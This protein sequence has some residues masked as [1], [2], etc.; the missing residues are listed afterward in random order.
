MTQRN[1]RLAARTFGSV[2]GTGWPEIAL[3]LVICAVVL[4]SLVVLPLP[5]NRSAPPGALW[6]LIVI[7]MATVAITRSL[8]PRFGLDARAARA[9]PDPLYT[10]DLA[11][12]IL[13]GPRP[14]VLLAFVAA[15][16]VAL[17]RGRASRTEWIA[18][19]RQTAAA[20][21]AT[22]VAALVYRW[23]SRLLAPPMSLVH[24]HLAAALVAAAVLLV[25]V[26]V[27]RALDDGPRAAPRALAWRAALADQTMRFQ[28]LML[29]IGPLLPLAEVLDDVEAELAWLL[30]LVPLFAIYYLALVSIRMEQRTAELQ[31]TVEQLGVARQREVELTGYA[32]LVT[33]AQEE[34]RRRL[35]RDLH[36]DTAQTLV[37]LSRGLDSLSTQTIHSSP[38]ARDVRFVED[39][40]EL[41]KRSLESIRRACQD[42]R[43]SVLDDLGLSAALEIASQRDD[44]ARADLRVSPA[45]RARAVAPGGRGDDL[46]HRPGG[47]HQRAPS[48]RGVRGRD[49]AGVSAVGAAPHRAGRW[50]R[51]RLPR[52]VRRR[53]P[54]GGSGAA[55]SGLGLLGMRERAA[56][57]GAHLEITSAAASGT[58][59]SVDV[60]AL[61]ET[62]AEIPATT[63]VESH[64]QPP[65]AVHQE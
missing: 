9:L 4:M 13:V 1:E 56:L 63:P 3:P 8:R 10:L 12:V 47:D 19:A 60:S 50:P 24:A 30:F 40:S 54:G 42:L 62:P 46:S 21:L 53:A 14:A 17:P 58:S 31:R 29:A 25:S 18:V 39:L 51:I 52:N 61:G 41:A 7:L 49:R 65:A 33:R 2:L 22:L 48:R 43:P 34:E 35:A 15:L 26:G 28:A 59:V 32:A 44:P 57:I 55:R 23:L 16:L 64:A 6:V 45:R 37:A 5:A 27:L 11:T 20:G 38:T 36:D